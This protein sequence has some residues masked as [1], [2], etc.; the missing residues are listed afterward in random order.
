MSTDLNAVVVKRCEVSPGLIILRV[1]SDG[2]ELPSFTPGQFGVIA[3]PGRAA[4]YGVSDVEEEL[5]DPDKMIK[6]A[7]S[8]ASSSVE[9]EYIEFYI[10]LVPSGAL[11]PRLFALQVGDRLWMSPKASG[12]FTLDEVPVDQH[13]VLISTG[14][15]LAPYISMLRTHL[16]CGGAQRFAV[17]HGARHSWDLGYRNELVTLAKNCENASNLCTI[18]RPDE[19]PMEWT[20]PSGYVQDL[21]TSGMLTKRFGFEPTPDNTHIFLC[22]TPKMIDDMTSI[23][24][25]DGFVLHSKKQPGQIHAER[26][27]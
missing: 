11:T 6:R 3:L 9:R 21:W 24:E 17:L 20:G 26:Y 16:I 12:L 4:R 14:T 1:E 19:E 5:V 22:G 27:W 7:Y 25:N 15:G 13:V 2:W 23:L 10:A 8:I 18:S